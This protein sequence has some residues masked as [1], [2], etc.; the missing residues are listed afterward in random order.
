MMDIILNK[1]CFWGAIEL[2]AIERV[3]LNM[4]INVQLDEAV[5]SYVYCPV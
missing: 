2:E 4:A 1:Y 3:L 5:S